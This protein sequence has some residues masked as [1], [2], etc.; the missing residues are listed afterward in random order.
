MLSP[1]FHSTFAVHG[2]K[3]LLQTNFVLLKQVVATLIIV[4]LLTIHD[5]IASA[6]PYLTAVDF[7]RANFLPLD[8]VSRS[9]KNDDSIAED[10]IRVSDLWATALC[11]VLLKIIQAKLF[12]SF[13]L[14]AGATCSTGYHFSFSLQAESSLEYNSWLNRT[15]VLLYKNYRF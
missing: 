1:L 8:R 10:S 9:V 15:T 12:L 5:A 7:A 11:S 2:N 3:M 13:V 4:T 6:P 14:P